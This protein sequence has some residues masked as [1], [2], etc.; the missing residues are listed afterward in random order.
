MRRVYA[1]FIARALVSSLALK[2]YAILATIFAMTQYVS[3]ID[4]YTNAPAWNDL[5]AQYEFFAGA[6][7]NTEMAVWGLSVGLLT[8]ISWLGFDVLSK[9]TA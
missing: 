3:F 2:C 8:V 6:L 7:S 5:G 1:I 9:K 4:V